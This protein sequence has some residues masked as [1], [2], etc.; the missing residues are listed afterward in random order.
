MSDHMASE[1][2]NC[3]EESHYSCFY[4]ALLLSRMQITLCYM[5]KSITV[6]Q[7]NLFLFHESH[8]GSELHECKNMLTEL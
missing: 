5:E 7:N 3:I 2:C 6:T 1:K 8:A 4:E